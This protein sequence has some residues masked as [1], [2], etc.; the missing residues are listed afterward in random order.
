[1]FSV[2]RV[3][4]FDG[5]FAFIRLEV[6]ISFDTVL[7]FTIE[8]LLISTQLSPINAIVTLKEL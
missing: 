5:V 1:M 2:S 8:Y 3:G 6:Y 4:N 7:E